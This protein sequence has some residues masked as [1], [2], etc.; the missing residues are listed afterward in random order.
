[1]APKKPIEKHNTRNTR[2]IISFPNLPFTSLILPLDSIVITPLALT[3][4]D[5]IIPLHLPV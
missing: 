2:Y 4:I 1:M 5:L 3:Y